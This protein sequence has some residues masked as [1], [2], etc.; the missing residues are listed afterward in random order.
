MRNDRTLI[1][2]EIALSVALAVVLN[3]LKPIQL[4]YGGSVSLVMLPIIV[5]A[6]RRG[7]LVGI[8]TGALYGVIDAQIDPYVVHPVQ[9]L[10]DYPV[11]YALVGLAGF[12]RALWVKAVVDGR[13]RRAAWTVVLP[14]VAIGALGRYV[15]HVV[16]GFVFFGE[17][18]P[19]GQ[20]VLAYSMIYN[21]FV[22]V[23]A[24]ACF[25]AAL[26]LLPALG[27]IGISKTESTMG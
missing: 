18:A 3:F 24:A 9:Y 6:L 13:M 21:S 23:S 4:P 2:V 7:V 11:A 10:L 12:G 16:S 20:P 27:N 19:E 15:A 1:M 5:I 14:S 26:V 17:Y 8:L 22:L 25:A